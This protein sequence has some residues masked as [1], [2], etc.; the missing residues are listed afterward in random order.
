MFG[1]VHSWLLFLD[2]CHGNGNPPGM[3]A[4]SSLASHAVL[5][6]AGTTGSGE[7]G[8]TRGACG[9]AELAGPFHLENTR[10]FMCLVMSA[11]SFF[12]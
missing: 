6:V 8:E 9:L 5:A 12:F 3:W 1:L 7:R 4:S 10:R 11:A 2:S